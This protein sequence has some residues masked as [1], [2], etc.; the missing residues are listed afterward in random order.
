MAKNIGLLRLF[1]WWN[2]QTFG[3]QLW[4]ALY[5]E[6]VGTDEFGNRYYQNAT[7][8]RRWVLYNGTVEASRVPPDW[9][10]WLHFTF[11]EP[12]TIAPLRSKSF[13]LPYVPNL[14]GLPGAY[15]PAGSL[16]AQGVRAPATADYEAW[17]PEQS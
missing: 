11:R 1:T 5:G 2:G 8:S 16:A 9:H 17:S 10:G 3:T 7:G 13:E 4:T 6:F 14:S 12:P 15:R